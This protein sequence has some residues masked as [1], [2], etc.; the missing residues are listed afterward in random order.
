[1]IAADRLLTKSSEGSLSKIRKCRATSAICFLLRFV[2]LQLFVD[3][4]LQFADP[5]LASQCVQCAPFGRLIQRF[6]PIRRQCSKLDK[7]RKAL[8]TREVSKESKQLKRKVII[9]L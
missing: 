3:R 4:R 2:T 7:N 5:S 6:Q 8:R 9:H 1:M